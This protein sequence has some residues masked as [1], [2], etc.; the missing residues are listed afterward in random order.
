[1]C[2][3][4]GCIEIS[5]LDPIE[6]CEECEGFGKVVKQLTIDEL[7]EQFERVYS[8]YALNKN[9]EGIYTYADIQFKWMG[10]QS[11]SRANNIIKE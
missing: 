8:D 7:R 6:T 1:M 3:G 5:S 10:F 2:E 9:S 11:C 4:N